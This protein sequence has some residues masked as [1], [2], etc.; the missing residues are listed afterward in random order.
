MCIL[1][2]YRQARPDAFPLLFGN[3]SNAV[4]VLRT[5]FSAAWHEMLTVEAATREGVKLHMPLR[6]TYHDTLDGT[7]LVMSLA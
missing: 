4:Q 7:M 3:Q 2:K 1:R 5:V 6:C